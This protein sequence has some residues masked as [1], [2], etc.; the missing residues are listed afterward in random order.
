MQKN[1]LYLKDL[2]KYKVYFDTI[3][4]QMLFSDILNGGS[5][6]PNVHTKIF[7]SKESII[8]ELSVYSG[9]KDGLYLSGSNGELHTGYLPFIEIK[10]KEV[11][12]KF[13]RYCKQQVASGKSRPSE[14]P[15]NLLNE[16]LTFEGQK[17]VLLLEVEELNRRLNKFTEV[18][19]AIQIK[20]CLQSKPE[21]KSINQFGQICEV[22]F[23]PVKNCR[24]VLIIDCPERK[25]YDGFSCS[26]YFEFI[27]RPYKIA[28]S[29]LAE[30]N[31]E[32]MK[33]AIRAGAKGDSFSMG[34]LRGSAAVIPTIPAT[35][36]NYK[37]VEKETIL[38]H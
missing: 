12:E 11:D 34:F 18:E 9:G 19:K 27:V 33:I 31:R 3:D 37:H 7:T 5:K 13:E 16:K 2:K 17:Y 14:L 25:E 38:K 10:L 1:K 4:R 28:C 24:G 20:K 29:E 21:G 23:M 30:S 6:Q 22:D 36:K 32:K 35:C 8:S 15:N 26:D